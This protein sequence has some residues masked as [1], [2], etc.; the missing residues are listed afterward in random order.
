CHIRKWVPLANVANEVAATSAMTWHVGPTSD[1]WW[2]LLSDGRSGG[3]YEDGDQPEDD[4]CPKRVR[5]ND[6]YE[7]VGSKVLKWTRR[8]RLRG[9]GP[10]RG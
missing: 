7:A 5:A 4:T 2:Q 10:T 3:G 6:W 8:W 9:R 1:T